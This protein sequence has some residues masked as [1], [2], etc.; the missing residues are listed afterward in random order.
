MRLDR[1]RCRSAFPAAFGRDG[2]SA[3]GID[4]LQVRALAAF[5]LLGSAMQLVS[6]TLPGY[7]RPEHWATA[8]VAGTAVGATSS[9]LAVAR[10]GLHRRA[11]LPFLVALDTLVALTLLTVADNVNTSLITSAFAALMVLAASFTGLAELFAFGAVTNAVLVMAVVLS[12]ETW[13]GSL[14]YLLWSEFGL[15][16]P[17]YAVY[18]LRKKLHQGAVLAH[19]ISLLDPLTEVRNRRGVEFEAPRLVAHAREAGALVGALV[20]DLDHFKMVNDTFGHAAGDEVL[21]TVATVLRSCVRSDDV[22]ARLGG[23]E[24]LVLVVL[25]P[26]ELTSL[27]ERIRCEVERAC[28]RWRLTVSIGVFWVDAAAAV[29][30]GD[31]GA[32]SSTA[33]SIVWSLVDRAD[34]L[35]YRAKSAG[36]NRVEHL[37]AV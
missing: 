11:V 28:R 2:R 35:T 10:W 18:A 21:R 15:V 31:R 13:Q 3:E 36:R 12:H 7:L 27:A 29:T 19:R 8:I 32:S 9:A 20:C 16:L 34:E 23:E 17:A 1:T 37:H 33:Q 24:F 14:M 25:A 26:A 4:G 6:V 30:A 5:L 22:V